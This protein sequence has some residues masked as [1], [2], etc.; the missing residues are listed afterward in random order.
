M[1]SMRP[2]SNGRLSNSDFFST[3][4]SLMSDNAFLRVE[5]I[6]CR[7]ICGDDYFG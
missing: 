2:D 7:D 1:R 5:L 4:F 3:I 6:N